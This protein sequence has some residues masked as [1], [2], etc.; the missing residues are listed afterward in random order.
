MSNTNGAAV[1]N[2]SSDDHWRHG[3]TF[4]RI[5]SSQG[6]ADEDNRDTH[7]RIFLFSKESRVRR[8]NSQLT[9]AF[10]MGDPSGFTAPLSSSDFPEPEMACMTGNGVRPL[11]FDDPFVST[12]SFG[13]TWA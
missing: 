5:S 1:S 13:L 12:P 6:Q 4:A 11:R 7:A 8:C 9:G 10:E 3:R 2:G